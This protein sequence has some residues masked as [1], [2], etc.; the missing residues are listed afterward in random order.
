MSHT[1]KDSPYHCFILG[2]HTPAD[3][4]QK[5]FQQCLLSLCLGWEMIVDLTLVALTLLVLPEYNF[6]LQ[7]K[8]DY[9]RDT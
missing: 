1:E 2:I 5:S 9:F 3:A 7:L 4:L 8:G 6:Q